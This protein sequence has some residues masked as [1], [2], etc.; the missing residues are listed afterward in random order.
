MRPTRPAYTL[1]E[2]LLALAIS[3]MLLAA[4]YAVVGYQLRYAQSGRDLVER[5]ALARAILRRVTTDISA[6]VTLGDAGRFRRT[7]SQQGTQQGSGGDSSGGGSGGA[8]AAGATVSG[9]SGASSSSG[10]QL[11]LGVIGSSTEVHLFLS[12]VPVEALADDA[13]VTC[14]LRRV[15]YWLPDDTQGLCRMEV[16]LVTSDDATNTDLPGDAGPYHF[17]PEVRQLEFSYFD[18]SSWQDSWDST[19]TGS[20]GVTPQGS[21]RAI[22]VKITVQVPGHKELKTYRHVVHVLTAGGTP[23]SS[24]EGG[25]TP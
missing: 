21:P 23:Q 24:S 7:Q 15:S 12:R 5:T 10:I 19:Q 13:Q 16:N 4:V 11:P 9:D 25:T 8:P 20:D 6:A 14:D 2:V 1:L 22:A 3:V 18:G 17:A